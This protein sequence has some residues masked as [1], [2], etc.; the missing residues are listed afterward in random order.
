MLM[1]YECCQLGREDIQPVPKHIFFFKSWYS[2]LSGQETTYFLISLLMNLEALG[3]IS[4][5]QAK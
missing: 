2:C 4:S 1:Y 3:V 5:N